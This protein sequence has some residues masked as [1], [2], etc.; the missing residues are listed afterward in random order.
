MYRCLRMCTSGGLLIL[1]T[2]GTAVAQNLHVRKKLPIGVLVSLTG[3]WSTLGRNT[4]AALEIGAAQI[5]AQSEAQ[6]AGYRVKLLARDTQLSPELALEELK[7]LDKRGVKIVIG[8]QSSAELALLKP[9]ADAHDILL[10]SQSS[11]ASTLAI[12]GDNVF[13]FCPDDRLEAEAIVTLMQQDGIRTLVP[14]WRGDAGNDGLH[15]SV[16]AA[17]IASGGS[18]TD[19]YRY[20]PATT[21]FSTAITDVSSQVSQARVGADPS[22][23][24]VY[25]AGFDEVVDIFETASTNAVLNTT[26]WYGSDGIANSYALL[27]APVGAAFSARVGLP[28]PAFGL[29]PSTK[30]AWQPLATEIQQV[31]GVAPDAFAL[32]AYDALFVAYRALQQS[33]GGK[34]FALLKE[35]FITTADSYTGMTGPTTLNA[36]GD[37]TFSD[38]DFWAIRPVNGILSW[39]VIGRYISGIL[40]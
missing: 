32:A 22:T 6:D 29:D 11:T 20:D 34:D 26:T 25:L 8:P 7:D 31:T 38:F 18:V 15:D 35:K 39:V 1:L 12:Q 37:R 3:S 13:R 33:R 16:R 21:D 27:S 9:Y 36:A 40:Y 24:A 2:C 23:V 4:Q 17:F 10:I 19:G 28:N 14:I 5:N 30:D